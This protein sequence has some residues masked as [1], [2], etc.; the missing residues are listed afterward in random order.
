MREDTAVSHAL[1]DMPG[2]LR[3]AASCHVQSSVISAWTT[4]SGVCQ[5]LLLCSCPLTWEEAKAKQC[6]ST[7]RGHSGRSGSCR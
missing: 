3:P 1:R 4:R 2:R 6:T 7:Q 5:H